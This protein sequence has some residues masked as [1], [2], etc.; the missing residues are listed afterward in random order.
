M[1]VGH[2]VLLVVLGSLAS[3]SVMRDAGLERLLD[4][5]ELVWELGPGVV[6]FFLGPAL[7]GWVASEREV[8]RAGAALGLS[9]ASG[10]FAVL[11]RLVETAWTPLLHVAV[12]AL[13]ALHARRAV[14]S[15]A[16]PAA[17]RLVATSAIVAALGWL[18]FATLAFWPHRDHTPTLATWQV[19]VATAAF[20]LA[21][22]ELAARRTR[23][24]AW[25]AVGGWLLVASPHF[26]SSGSGCV[27]WPGFLEHVLFPRLLPFVA[28]G[29]WA[30]PVWRWLAGSRAI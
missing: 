28:L 26:S 2:R 8:V 21:L 15:S 30:G 20:A 12:W 18:G 14:V 25:I 5:P 24:L 27:V 9:L 16:E 22:G 10:L 7:A 23:A 19:V 29:L 13:L 11:P 6:L 4:L 1:P 3:L 17:R